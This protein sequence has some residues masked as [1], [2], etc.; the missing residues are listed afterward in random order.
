LSLEID[1][2]AYKNIADSCMM[3]LIPNCFSLLKT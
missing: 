3:L 2:L 1:H